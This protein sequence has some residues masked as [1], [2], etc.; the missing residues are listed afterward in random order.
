MVVVGLDGAKAMAELA[1]LAPSA[2]A[3]RLAVERARTLDLPSAGAAEAIA[4]ALGP[5]RG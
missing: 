3:R 5:Y 4:A 1:R 2:D